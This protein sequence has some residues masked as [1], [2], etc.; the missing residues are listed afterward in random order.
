LVAGNLVAEESGR[1]F[2]EAPLCC[3]PM[4]ET[5]ESRDARPP[6]P[7]RSGRRALGILVALAVIA[8][9]IGAGAL[10][11]VRWCEG[12]D[13]LREA[14]SVRVPEGATGAT[15][16]ELLHERGV[17]RCGGFVGRSLLQKTG[18]DDDIHAGTY[19]L[20]TNMTLHEALAVL[21]TPPPPVPTVRLTI[22]EGYRLT[23]IA[24]RA[25]E[26]LGISARA[27]LRLAESEELSL[28]PYL[29]RGTPTTEGFLF[30]KTYEF[31]EAKATPRAV[32]E[33]LLEQFRIEA[34]SLPWDK[35][36]RLGVSAYEV[37]IIASMVEREARV[38]QERPQIAA[39]I[40]NRLRRGMN[41]G[42]DATLQY[43]DPDPSNG[44]TESDL[45]I[46]SPYNTRLH[47]GLPP[48][49]IASPGRDALLAALEPDDVPYLYYV[50]CGK[51][52]HH[53][54]STSY[55]DFLA[56]RQRCGE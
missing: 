37:V 46:H 53:E 48:T 29:P 34:N 43:V 41:L 30:P 14:I 4:L 13:G 23:Q 44:L 45:R 11:Y 50:L 52:G 12:G 49:P 42:I 56:D 19:A 16:A 26:E 40:Y 2:P 8:G 6:G 33:R 10:A 39:V 22:P 51:D 25:A 17:T 54:F 32:V 1:A 21:A 36:K 31:V 3:P 20:T 47:P 27:I 35:A 9:A 24:E 5:L 55:D 7:R 28:P 38:P 18:L 15:V